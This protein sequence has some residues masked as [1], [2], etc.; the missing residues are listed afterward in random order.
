MVQVSNGELDRFH[1][2]K[3]VRV[4]LDNLDSSI[5]ERKTEVG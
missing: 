5:G 3:V 1:I 4:L 2:V